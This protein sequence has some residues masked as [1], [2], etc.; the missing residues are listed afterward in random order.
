M[1]YIYNITFIL[2]PSEEG[3]FVEWYRSEAHPGLSVPDV[4]PEG[5]SLHT[6]VE[7]GGEKPGPDHGLSVALQARFPNLDEAHKWNDTAL[8]RVLEKF[9]K[10]FGPHAAFFTTVLR[11][12]E[13]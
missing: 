2:S 4:A 6:V 3:R 13:P 1:G 5:L 10:M 8:P 9:M 12:F 7:I 11:E